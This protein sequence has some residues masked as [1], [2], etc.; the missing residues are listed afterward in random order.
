MDGIVQKPYWLRIGLIFHRK[1]FHVMGRRFVFSIFGLA[2]LLLMSLLFISP[3]SASIDSGCPVE[4]KLVNPAMTGCNNLPALGPGNDTRANLLLLLF[5]R[6][7]TPPERQPAQLLPP[8]DPFSDSWRSFRDRFF[9]ERPDD[10]TGYAD[11]EGSRCRSNASGA[12]GFEAALNAASD[13]P[14]DERMILFAARKALMPTCADNGNATAAT[15]DSAVEKLH[16]ASGQA[17]ATYLR[18]V[19]AFYDGRFDEAATAFTSLKG[20]A[21]P[22][23][24]DTAAYMVARTEV[25]RMQVGAFDQYGDYGG[26]TKVDQQAATR[27]ETSL[28]AYLHDYPKGQYVLSARGLLRRVNWVAGR[29]DKL[30]AQYAELIAMPPA[31]RGISDDA[32]AEEIDNKLLPQL[33][34]QMTSDPTLLAVIDLLRMRETD[35]A[36]KKA[37][38][39]R[40]EL[41]A[42]R[43]AFGSASPLFDYLLA[44]HAFHVDHDNASVLK[45]LPDATRRRDGD[46]LWF[47]RQL[48][49]G[50]ALEAAGDRNARGFWIELYPGARN[51][52]QRSAVD[53]AL[54]M[55]DERH[56]RLQ[57]VFA[58][59]SLVKNP[60]IRETLL[61]KVAPAA[62]LR[63]QSRDPAVP[64][65][66][67]EMAL[68]TLLYKEVTR[69]YYNDFLADIAGVPAN[70]PV[71]GGIV[72]GGDVPPPLGVF[73]QTK[74]QSDIDCPPLRTTVGTLARNSSS[75]RARLC[76]A[77][78]ARVNNMDAEPVDIQ[79]PK[80]QLGG[81]AS[82]FPGK[83]YARAATYQAIIADARAP[84]ADKAYALFRAINCYA[85]AGKNQCGGADVPLAQRKAWYVRLK[86]DYPSSPWAKELRYWW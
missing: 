38:I 68:F 16:S 7:G 52:L 66:E 20:S 72:P 75:P 3:A 8:T 9:P 45:L 47:S 53:L 58:A 50:L 18:G 26:S 44:V 82:L 5:D 80:D 65:H 27:A 70:A 33:T 46:N 42:Q 67:R 61:T 25:N 32:L 17:F 60:T 41:E 56:G 34:L 6:H 85:P 55:H 64:E 74:T 4:W 63:Q 59:A 30:A 37:S 23:L 71:E 73:T 43:Q 24:A 79:P 81:T 15:L 2:S 31:K 49:R 13:V 40:D 69:G 48:L 76:V 39:T 35:P 77:E 86:Q 57:D 1:V 12:S 54:A 19:A 78:F 10:T 21:V 11:G 14:P 29:T 51:S 36:E 83:P 22:W 62:L 84:A 28:N